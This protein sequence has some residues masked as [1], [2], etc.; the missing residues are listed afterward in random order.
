MEEITFLVQGSAIDPYRVTFTKN[1]NNLNA[2]CTCPAGENGQYCKHRLAI[3]GGDV[4]AI[5]SKNELEVET[6]GKS[7]WAMD[8]DRKTR[9]DTTE[10]SEPNNPRVP[11]NRP[12]SAHC[13]SL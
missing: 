10:S 9:N 7:G 8:R 2:F 11:G 13:G 12:L 6:V 5:T 3:L 1:K 4:S